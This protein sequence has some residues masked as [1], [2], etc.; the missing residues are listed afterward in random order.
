MVSH[1]GKVGV[2]YEVCDCG[3]LYL[4]FKMLPTLID[5]R[6]AFVL[7]GMGGCITS[8]LIHALTSVIAYRCIQP[9]LTAR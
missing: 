7:P 6:S 4:D 1:L 9:S 8:V 2:F 5:S 3:S